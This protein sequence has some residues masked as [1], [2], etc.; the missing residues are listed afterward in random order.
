MKT[1]LLD[2]LRANYWLTVAIPGGM[3][4]VTTAVFWGLR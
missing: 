2:I 4:V 1:F 3:I